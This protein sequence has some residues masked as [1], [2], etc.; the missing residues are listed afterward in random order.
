MG[1]LKI[2]G[3]HPMRKELFVRG[4]RQGYVNVDDV[5]A[6]IPP[7]LMTAAERW[8]LYFSLRSAEVELR[9]GQG[10]LVTPD[11]IVTDRRRPGVRGAVL[12]PPAYDSFVEPEH[13]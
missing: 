10:R 12:R 5:E 8:L 13:D 3:G 6:A 9:D 7:G 1:L 4:L 2:G 11:D